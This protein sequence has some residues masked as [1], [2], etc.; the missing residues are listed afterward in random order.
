MDLGVDTDLAM[1]GM[2]DLVDGKHTIMDTKEEIVRALIMLLSVLSTFL[3]CLHSTWCVVL[4]V[5]NVL[6]YPLT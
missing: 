3:W 2:V 4:L 6:Q 1:E 5:K